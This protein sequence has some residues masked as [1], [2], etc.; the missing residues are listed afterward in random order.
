MKNYGYIDLFRKHKENGKKKE[1][2]DETC[3]HF[4]L[5]PLL[6]HVHR[7]HILINK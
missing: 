2:G 7:G 3:N 6:N 1:N 4:T 5:Q